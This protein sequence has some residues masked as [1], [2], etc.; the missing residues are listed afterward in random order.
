[1]IVRR[2]VCFLFQTDRTMK[3]ILSLFI[4][5]LLA[6]TLSGCGGSSDAGRVPVYPA[7]GTVTLFGSPLAGATVAFA[8]ID[9]QPTAFGNTDSAGN[10]QLTTYDFGD[11]AAAGNFKVVISKHAPAASG[12]GGDFD[13]ADH[14][15]AEVA[16]SGHD[17]EGEKAGA[18]LVPGN[19]SSSD[20]TPLSAEVKSG[21]ENKFT[22]EIK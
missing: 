11:G 8:P 1:M 10:F 5:G 14:E 17:A 12:G 6:A 21:G 22:L 3:R 18:N 4:V 20:D 13:G 9:G 19:Y 2:T 7:S 16:A 15:A